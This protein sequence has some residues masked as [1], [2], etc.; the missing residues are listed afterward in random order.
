MEQEPE[1][2]AT[3]Q[4]SQEALVQDFQLQLAGELLAPH[5]WEQEA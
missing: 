5:E 3:K 1:Q 2:K 4:V